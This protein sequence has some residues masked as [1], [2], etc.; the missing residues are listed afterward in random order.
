MIVFTQCSS[1]GCRHACWSLRSTELPFLHSLHF[2][3]T[4]PL[5]CLFWKGDVK[6]VGWHLYFSFPPLSPS[7]PSLPLF[8]SFHQSHS[9]FFSPTSSISHLP[10]PASFTNPLHRLSHH[11][12]CFLAFPR[13]AP[14]LCSSAFIGTQFPN[15]HLSPCFIFYLEKRTRPYSWSHIQ[16]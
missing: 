14:A 16:L 1:A 2:I 5:Q 3:N 11:G 15:W 7:S 13:V 10:S 12:P 6:Q 9:L 8:L 4:K